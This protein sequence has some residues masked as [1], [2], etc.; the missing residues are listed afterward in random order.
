MKKSSGKIL[1][2]LFLAMAQLCTIA[3]V[4]V[5]A[6]EGAKSG[7]KAPDLKYGLRVDF[8]QGVYT[9]YTMDEKTR[10][11]RLYR[12][13]L[14]RSYQRQLQYSFTQSP[15][16]SK[17]EQ[18]LS[19][20]TN[21][22]SM[23]YAFK[24]GNTELLYDS[25]NPKAATVNTEF[26]DAISTMALLNHQFALIY[27][28][29]TT[30]MDVVGVDQ[31]GDIEWLRNYVTVEGKDALDTAQK[32]TWLHGTSNEQAC[33]IA[34]VSK[35]L[36]L[37]K[38][39]IKPDSIWRSPI[40]LR[41]DGIDFTDTVEMRVVSYK[42]GEYV[43]EG[44]SRALKPVMNKDAR[45]FGVPA[46]VPVKV[47]AGSG[48]IIMEISSA[49]WVRK[50]DIDYVAEVEAQYRRESFSQKIETKASW[51]LNGRYKW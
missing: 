49:G 50:V 8:K 48:K 15:G 11:K 1:S 3:G 46:P 14:T 9:S 44:Q 27:S 42:K 6:Q 28:P 7:E 18:G 31:P 24:E 13:S 51:K 26:P 34:D 22:D 23:R 12:D 41:L 40:Q 39:L 20:V 25:Q 32:F 35:G 10:V 47:G 29:G 2:F 19:I 4:Y 33:Y 36:I 17:S 16:K 43:L 38:M 5:Y 45:F 30:V 37:G 21:I